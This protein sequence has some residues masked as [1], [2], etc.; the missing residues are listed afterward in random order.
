[1]EMMCPFCGEPLIAS[2]TLLHFRC[3]TRG[4]DE[5]GEYITGRICDKL[6]YLRL[7]NAKDDEIAE[8]KRKLEMKK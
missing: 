5:K 3:G 2:G 4:P 7:I 6:S 1:M 8:L